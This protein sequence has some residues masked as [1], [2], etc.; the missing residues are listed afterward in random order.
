MKLFGNRP[1]VSVVMASYMFILTLF[2]CNDVHPGQLSAPLTIEQAQDHH[3]ED[4]DICSPFCICS[5]CSGTAAIP[6]GHQPFIFPAYAHEEFHP[7]FDDVL[8]GFSAI[9]LRP[10]KS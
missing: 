3:Q 7:S 4:A 10:P 6:Q 8:A 5:C 2:P 9:H 1:M